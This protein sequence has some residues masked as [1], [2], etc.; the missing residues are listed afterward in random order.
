[1]NIHPQYPHKMALGKVITHHRLECHAPQGTVHPYH[2]VWEALYHHEQHVVT[3]VWCG[4]PVDE[5]EG[6]DDWYDGPVHLP[7]QPDGVPQPT[8]RLRLFGDWRNP[9]KD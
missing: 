5:V 8:V 4:R 1:M 3:Q 2:T 7:I 6:L 9:P